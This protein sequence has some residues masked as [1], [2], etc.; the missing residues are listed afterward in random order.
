MGHALEAD[1]TSASSD[2][3]LALVVQFAQQATVV[4]ERALLH[5]Q[6]I[7]QSR[8]DQEIEIAGTFSGACPRWSRPRFREC[9]W[10]FAKT[11]YAHV[12]AVTRPRTGSAITPPVAGICARP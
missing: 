10:S 7:R 5:E 12:P 11:T 9:S 4:I 1:R 2:D 6:L 3:D 8:I